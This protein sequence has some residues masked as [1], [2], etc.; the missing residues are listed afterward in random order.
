MSPIFVNANGTAA[1]RYSGT[2]AISTQQNGATYRLRDGTRGNGIETYNVNH[3]SSI[4]PDNAIDFTDADNNWT[5]LEFHNSN[6][7]DGALDA[8]WGAM[9][10]YDYFKNVHGRNSYDNNNGTIR[11]YVHFGNEVNSARWNQ[12]YNIILYG[13][14]HIIFD[15]L[16]SLDVIGHEISHGVCHFTAGLVYKKEAG[17]INES[18]SDIWAACIENH[19][20]AN[21][22]IWLCGEDIDLRP[23]HVALRSMS[24]PKDERQP[25]TYGGTYWVD[26]LDCPPLPTND[27]CGVHIN[28]GV[29]NHWFYLLSVGGS[30]T[31]DI[32]NDFAVTG[33]GISHA[34]KIVYRAES[35]YMTS[36]TIFHQ[37]RSYT[38]QAA[39]DLYGLNSNEVIEVINAW[40]AVGV[41]DPYIVFGPNT[42]N[43][44]NNEVFQLIGTLPSDA[45]VHWRVGAGF[46]ITEGQNTNIVHIQALTGLP[47][48]ETIYLDILNNGEVMTTL[49]HNVTVSFDNT[50]Y[51]NLS[52]EDFIISSNTT[53]NGKNVL[54]V[55][56]TVPFGVTLTIFDTLFLANGAKLIVNYGGSII[57]NN[58]VFQPYCND[59]N[60]RALVQMNSFANFSGNLHVNG[61][62]FH[63]TDVVLSNIA[64]DHSSI[65][66][67]SSIDGYSLLDNCSFNNCTLFTSNKNQI[68][69]TG[70]QFNGT[71][72]TA[73]AS[74]SAITAE[75]EI[76]YSDFNNT[77]LRH[78]GHELTLKNNRF[79]NR[80]DVTTF[81]SRS[82]VDSCYFDYSGYF[83]CK[84]SG[85]GIPVGVTELVPFAKITHNKFY[86]T[87]T[88]F[89]VGFDMADNP[90]YSTAAI[91]LER[92]P[93]FEITNNEIIRTN[94]PDIN[95]VPP[96]FLI[97]PHGE[98]ISLTYAGNGD[99][100]SR[101][102]QNNEIIGAETGF[103]SYLSKAILKTNKIYNNHYG[104]RLFNNSDISLFGLTNTT[105]GTQE[106]RD[107]ESYE[108]YTSDGMPYCRYNMIKD[109]DNGGNANGDPLFYG[110]YAAKTTAPHD[111]LT[112]QSFVLCSNQIILNYWGNNFNAMDDIYPLSLAPCVN[113]QW[114]PLGTANP[115]V[116]LDETL[117]L[118]GIDE[119]IAGN[120]VDAQDIFQS[121]SRNYPNG[122]YAVMALH[123]LFALE[124]YLEND[125]ETLQSYYLHI[126]DSSLLA[127]A[128]FLSNRCNVELQNWQ[129]AI[130]WYESVL[131]DPLSSYQDSIFAVI[132]LS[133]IYKLMS[134]DTLKSGRIINS[135]Y[136]DIQPRDSREH[137]VRKAALLATLPLKITP[138][139]SQPRITG[140]SRKGWL[141]QNIP[142]P[143]TRTTVIEYNISTESSIELRIYNTLGQLIQ[144][145]PQ[146]KQPTGN[147][148][149]T[150]SL[151][152]LPVGMYSYLLYMDGERADGKKM[153]VK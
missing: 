101:L 44:C 120:Y 90:I 130:N 31:N 51:N 9:A 5:A 133:D 13:D 145:L 149:V 105:L 118:S 3:S 83:A 127:V 102:I 34:E 45:T 92:I 142:N 17:A 96:I 113:P 50:G 136:P 151:S 137:E 10:T 54:G 40:Y 121:V 110:D 125:Y 48:T 111:S 58:A 73:A 107:N 76:S 59:G 106:I 68:E 1:T 98:G 8:H 35:V 124:K 20:N 22:Q 69:I 109:S 108:I 53:W 26:Q 39:I 87:G 119:F 46:V 2:R 141:S 104:I 67:N 77:T 70:C 33:I 16:T 126:T 15:I 148:Q 6:K 49:A 80:S 47:S 37:A 123:E 103:L 56:A 122:Q 24:N 36:N 11:G 41:G 150:V 94:A 52:T 144:I 30:G 114:E 93:E 60:I 78:I 91:K 74:S 38:I 132:D 18:L 153:I 112:Q 62:N 64:F 19:A 147:H 4:P 129:D 14:G 7:D 85:G 25:D 97:S 135:R 61:I 89:I 43:V 12:L 131:D 29:M 116:S 84:Q 28:S 140:D 71:Q 115:I 100:D 57:S 152:G 72:I 95:G 117:Y 32:G 138:S 143:A 88:Y 27:Y 79:F 139:P 128:D 42:M 82:E 99:P 63:A 21:K 66:C 65:Q 134:E 81:N 23:N 75:T 55:N 146:G 86:S